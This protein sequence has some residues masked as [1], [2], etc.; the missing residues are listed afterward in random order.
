MKI[1]VIQNDDIGNQ[2]DGPNGQDLVTEFV[3]PMECG[4]LNMRVYPKVSGLSR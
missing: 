4:Q 3:K 1:K 2:N